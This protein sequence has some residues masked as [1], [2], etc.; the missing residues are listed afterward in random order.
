MFRAAFPTAPEDA[1]KAETSWVKLTYDTTGANKSGKARFAGTWVTPEVADSLAEGY[2]LADLIR[3]LTAATPNPEAIHRKKSTPT[4]HTPVSSPTPPVVATT[5]R[6]GPNPAKRRREASPAPSP[7]AAT[8]TPKP[9]PA[10][11]STPLSSR[12][13]KPVESTPSRLPVTSKRAPSPARSVVPPVTPGSLRRSTRLKS[14]A[15]TSAPSSEHTVVGSHSPKTPKVAMTAIREEVTPGGSDE[16][17]VD[18]DAAIARATEV[19]MHED[20]R[21]QRA[22]IERLK[23]ERV[24]KNNI[25]G[26]KTQEVIDVDASDEEVTLVNLNSASSKAQKRAR[27]EEQQQL[28]FNFREGK[29]PQ[30]GEQERA[31]VSNSRARGRVTA[32]RKQ[33]AWG[34]LAFA[35][36][37]SAM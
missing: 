31:I 14:P 5:P 3:P 13:E 4:Q 25:Q 22:L 15:P 9:P 33:L 37:L 21:E 26:E 32:E 36:G 18:E 27:E 7:S 19:D 29:W 2:A 34:A 23:A 35:A 30:V 8:T 17:A 6:D 10:A 11:K 20:V 1:E 24:W 16:T 12:V 28:R